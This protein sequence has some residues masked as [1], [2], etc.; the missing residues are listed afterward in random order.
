M[1]LLSKLF[2]DFDICGN[3]PKELNEATA[4][5]LGKAFGTYLTRHAY[6]NIVIGRDA[7]LSSTELAKSF[8]L[9]VLSTGCHVTHLGITILPTIK[10]LTCSTDFDAGVYVSK[11]GFSLDLQGAEGLHTSE[12]KKFNRL[13]A[14]EK[15]V[16]G[17]GEY[18]ERELTTKYLSY[19]Q[20]RFSFSKPHKIYLEPCNNVI[21]SIF[22]AL[23]L[24][25]VS[26]ANEADIRFGYTADGSKL[27]VTDEHGVKLEA[28]K[29]LLLLA[30]HILS[31]KHHQK[32]VYD[33][34][35]SDYVGKVI[36]SLG[37][38]AQPLAHDA[39]AF[40]TY[41]KTGEAVLAGDNEGAIY[42]GDDY[43]GYADAVYASLRILEILDISSEPLS[44]LTKPSLHANILV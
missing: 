24:Q 44:V 14:D 26:N 29:L 42:L 31:S 3:Y 9:G 5:H 19:L 40:R 39:V 41:P 7:S 15:Y 23:N 33:I 22:T 32:I 4:E 27:T 35:F 12:L 11:G 36:K 30:K 25:L 37:G 18:M 38:T 17:Q 13:V 21:L 16:I 20:T 43:F 8:I 1:K 2:C 6:K 34:K 10:F 28:Y